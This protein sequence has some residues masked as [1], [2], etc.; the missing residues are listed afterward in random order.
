MNSE[1]AKAP[2]T[3]ISLLVHSS[4]PAPLLTESCE[5]SEDWLKLKGQNGAKRSLNNPTTT[6]TTY[7]T[8]CT[9]SRTYRKEPTYIFRPV[10]TYS[11]L[12]QQYFDDDGYQ[13]KTRH[14]YIPSLYDDIRPSAYYQLDHH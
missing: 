12:K 2:K 14:R 5:S 1:G 9:M 11:E 10:Q 7:T 13:V 4:T 6:D 3:N 8:V